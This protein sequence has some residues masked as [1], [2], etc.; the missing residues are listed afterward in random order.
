M[1]KRTIGILIISAIVLFIGVGITVAYLVS[2]SVTVKNT[3]TVGKVEI[4]LSETTGENYKLV[5]GAAVNKDPVITLKAE[6]DPCFVYFKVN[7]TEKLSDYLSY[8]VADGWKALSGVPDVYYR[9]VEG[10]KEDIAFPLI[11]DNTVFVN[12]NLT[13]DDLAT[14]NI[15]PAITF[16]GYAIQAEGID[17][18]A[19]GW[20]QLQ[21]VG[22][23]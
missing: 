1:G 21:E 19:Q 3:F 14:V 4:T 5:P 8:S 7:N 9:Y 23:E 22:R 12:E 11:Q 18:A 17:T 16:F 15:T 10:T 2:S 13:E 20:Q 6:S